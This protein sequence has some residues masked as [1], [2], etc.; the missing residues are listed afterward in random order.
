MAYVITTQDIALIQNRIKDVRCKI[1]LLSYS[2]GVHTVIDTVEYII[3]GEYTENPDNNNRRTFNATLLQIDKNYTVGEYKKIWLDKRVRVYI[4]YA[5]PRTKEV[6]WYKKGI[7]VFVDCSGSTSA[8]SSEITISCSDLVCTLD[9]TAGGQ[10][11]GGDDAAQT[12]IP[13]N[14]EIRS[15]IIRTITQLGGIVNYRVDDVGVYSCLPDTSVD[16]LK[17]REVNPEWNKVP[18]DLEFDVGSTVWDILVKL[19]DLYPG[20]E[21]FFDEDGMFICQRIPNCD[22]DEIVLTNEIIDDLVVSE[23]GNVNLSQ[24]RNV[25]RVYGKSIETDRFT[26]AVVTEGNTYK[27]TLDSYADKLNTIIGIVVDADNIENMQIEITGN[28]TE[29]STHKIMKRVMET[30][31]DT[32]IYMLDVDTDDEVTTTTVIKYEPYPAGY[33]KAGEVYCF[34]YLKCLDSGETEP[35]YHW[36]YEGQFQVQALYKNEDEET[37][38]CVQKIG[39]RLQVLTGGEYEDIFSN[40]LAMERASYETWLASRLTDNIT[41][42]LIDI[43]FLS[44]NQKITYTPRNETKAYPYIIK[45]ISESFGTGLMSITMMRFYRLYPNIIGAK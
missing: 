23:S 13:Y 28:D 45:S 12:L 20:F 32:A 4:G 38:F 33:F 24:V 7:F 39:E 44:V 43:P 6:R 36:T 30:T 19:R 42:E 34:K 2:N 25:T 17:Q 11:D 10:I 5:D 18:Y 27:V 15:A 35:E 8:S 21:M 29:T 37:A 26:D 22:A 40:D 9:G 3:S 16:Y 1:E 31:V 14:T 41:L